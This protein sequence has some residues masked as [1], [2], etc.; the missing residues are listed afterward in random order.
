MHESALSFLGL[1]LQ[2]ERASLGTIIE[3]SRAAVLAGHWWPAVLPGLVLI[4]LSLAVYRLAER[5][6]PAPLGRS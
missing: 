2:D 3:Q 5:F 1:G 6:R 4:G